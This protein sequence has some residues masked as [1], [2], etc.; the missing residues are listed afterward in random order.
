MKEPACMPVW[1]S[2]PVLSKNPVLIKA[3]LDCAA[4]IHSFRFI[5]VRLS[6]SMMP[7]LIVL[8]GKS[9]NFSISEKSSSVN[10][11]SSGPCIFGLTI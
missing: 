11:T 2:S 7:I 3:T 5:L 10:L 6:S 4:L 1:I 8:F 9:N